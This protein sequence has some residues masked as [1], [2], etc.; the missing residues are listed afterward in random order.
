MTKN[1][2][3]LAGLAALFAVGCSGDDTTP[4]DSADTAGATTG[5]DDDT[6]TIPNMFDDATL[7]G[8]VVCSGDNSEVTFDF[9]FLGDAAE[10]MLDEADTYNAPSTYGNW[11]DYHTLD[12]SGFTDDGGYTELSATIATGAGLS[13]WASG[14]S[15]L[16]TCEDHYEYDNPAVMTYIARAYDLN[17]ALADCVAWGEDP[18]GFIAGTRTGTGEDYLSNNAR[19]DEADIA[20]CRTVSSAK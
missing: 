3:F 2:L 1:T 15:T 12:A 7:G 5:D 11:N 6:N 9:D 17:G 13:D 10:G 18:E 14:V 4:K 19:I 16:F 20:G 8:G